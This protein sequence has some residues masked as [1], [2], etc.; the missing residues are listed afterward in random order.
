MKELKKDLGAV[1]KGLKE[2]TQK[3]EKMIRQVEKLVRYLSYLKS[4]AWF[5]SP[6]RISI[7]LNAWSIYCFT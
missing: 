2:L 1:T 7:P 5:E 6:Q 4:T 3:T